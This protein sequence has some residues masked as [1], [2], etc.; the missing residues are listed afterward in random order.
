MTAAVEWMALARERVQADKLPPMVAARLYAYLG[1][2]MYEAVATVR[3]WKS[4]LEQLG[5]H[6]PPTV[7][8]P[9]R[10]DAEAV[11]AG[12]ASAV[13][14]SLFHTIG[15]E[16]AIE[17]LER[18][19]LGGA[20]GA[21]RALGEAIGRNV[22]LAAKS[23]G[24]SVAGKVVYKPR[25]GEL[26]WKP[27]PPKKLP[28]SMPGWAKVQPLALRRAADVERQEM[29]SLDRVKQQARIVHE[30]G[31]KL[32]DEERAI[33]GFWADN[34]GESPTPP[35]HW[36]AI[37]SQLLE[38]ESAELEDGVKVL[39]LVGIALHDAFVACW[40]AKYKFNLVRPITVIQKEHEPRWSSLLVTPPFPGFPSG[41]STGSFAAATVLTKLF[42]DVPFRDSSVAGKD[43]R[44]FSS[45]LDAA[46]EAGMSR[47][48]GGI[49]FPIDNQAGAAIGKL[50]G[51]KVLARV[52]L[53]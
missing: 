18:Q 1:V 22:V 10:Y 38:E 30:V 36:I 13:L 40:A 46:R 23:D 21:S 29:P 48:Y 14:Q 53:G 42:G 25:P 16:R 2:G 26:Y 27:T 28:A 33:A 34:P 7:R 12:A 31:L 52:R 45:L 37:A 15:S 39:A 11:V 50:V 51:E 49:H 17:T 41:H 6:K 43:P 47:I 24:A 4:A 35:G 32:T 5:A 3:G 9:G 20:S 19:Q 8:E 44:S